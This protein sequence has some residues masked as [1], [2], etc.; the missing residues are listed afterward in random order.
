M[1]TK[2]ATKVQNVRV[3][4]KYGKYISNCTTKRAY[5]L[6][7]R[8]AAFWTPEPDVLQLKY[9]KRD[10]KRF[11]RQAMERDNYTCYMITCR[12]I[13][14][15]NHPD[16]SH[17]HIKSRAKGGTDYPDN[18]ACCCKQCNE[19]KGHMDLEDFMKMKLQQM[20]KGEQDVERLTKDVSGQ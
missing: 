1:D 11:I 19:E 13:M 14:H 4:D 20:M 12:K 2:E 17:D 9:D 15:P 10:K 3:L 7:E 18:I 5:Q 8:K 6:L 16:L